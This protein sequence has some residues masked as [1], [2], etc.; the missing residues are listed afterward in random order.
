MVIEDAV[1]T[2]ISPD[3]I[4]GLFEMLGGVS[5][6]KNVGQLYADKQSKGVHWSPTLFFAAW[7]VWNLY[8]Y[9]HLN[10]TFSFIG[11]LFIVTANVVWFVMMM[12]YKLWGPHAQD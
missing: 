4:N 1:H 9:P 11:G 6:L 5:L 2:M 12:Y 8:Y 10:Q 7:G 3:I